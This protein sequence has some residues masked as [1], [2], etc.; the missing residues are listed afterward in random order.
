[1]YVS[2]L[3]IMQKETILDTKKRDLIVSSGIEKRLYCIVFPSQKNNCTK[4]SGLI[5]NSVTH[6]E[7]QLGV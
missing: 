6:N 3:T 1:M 2:I 4:I 7:V 5:R